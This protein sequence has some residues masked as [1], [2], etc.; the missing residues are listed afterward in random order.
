M[1]K[2]LL[3]TMMTLF[4]FI[5]VNAQDVEFGA[6]LGANFGSI[7]GNNTENIDPILSIINF[8]FYS[9]IPLNEKF[10]FQPELM[11]SI[12]GF[13]VDNNITRLNYL[14]IPLMGKYY[15]TKKLSLEA[16]PQVGF[17]LSAK[18]SM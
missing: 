9:E 7:Y 3:I 17:L 16:G 12:Q 4:E 5:N 14:N 15:V 2:L 1:K 11:Y 6:K 10:S 8:G 13:S 18:G